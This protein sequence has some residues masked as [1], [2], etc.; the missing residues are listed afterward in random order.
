MPILVLGLNAF[1]NA[2]YTDTTRWEFSPNTVLPQMGSSKM[3]SGLNYSVSYKNNKLEVYL[4]YYGKA[5]AGADIYTGKNP[6]DFTSNE[7]TVETKT[8]KKGGIRYIIHPKDNSEVQTLNFTFFDNGNADLDILM[9]NRSPI[10]Y[11]G[12]VAKQ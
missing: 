8:M 3:I 11:Y 4:P 9:S 6:L 5:Y 1:V 10:S 2:A 12:T 7:F